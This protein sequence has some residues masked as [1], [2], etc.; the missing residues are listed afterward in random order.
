MSRHKKQD[1]IIVVDIESTCWD[2]SPPRGEESDIIEIGICP[3][4]VKTLRPEEKRSI[5]VTPTRSNISD[6]CTQL[7][8]ITQEQI[9]EHGISLAEACAILKEEYDTTA[10]L[11]ASWGD[12]DRNQF[13]KVCRAHK[14]WYPFGSRHLNAKTLFA[15]AAGLRREVGLKEACEICKIPMEGTH[16]RGDSDAW[17][18]ARILCHILKKTR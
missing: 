14:I 4:N 12:Y 2:T 11:W 3:I 16:H 9:D 17:N 10:R 7:T 1:K 6:F 18:I 15:I 5:L 8:T 13:N